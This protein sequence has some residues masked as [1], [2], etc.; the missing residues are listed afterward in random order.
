[1][2]NEKI[3]NVPIVAIIKKHRNL[4]FGKIML[5]QMLDKLLT[6]AITEGWS[7]KELNAS[8]DAD[9]TAAVS[10]YTAIGFTEEY[11]YPLAYHPKNA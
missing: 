11:T 8:C 2:T 10:M 1:L 4:G 6:S 3:A 9:N 7:L 5:K